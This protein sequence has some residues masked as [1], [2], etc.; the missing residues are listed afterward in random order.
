MEALD[1]SFDVR[2]A[3]I[4]ANQHMRHSAYYDYA[5]HLRVQLLKKIG[6]DVITLSSLK[7]GPVLFR[8]EALFLREI[9]MDDRIRVNV[10]L[11]R[12]R[13]DGSRWTFFHEFFKDEG[14]VAATVTVDG[15]W[16]DLT[17]RKLIALPDQYLELA[18]G[19]VRT[20]DFEFE[21]KDRA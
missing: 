10:K 19:I 9:G 13:P 2:W 1:L 3:D 17:K 15:A 8:E 21:I 12:M 18:L 5:A 20:S 16:L 6:M 11:K 7:I 4:D 14:K